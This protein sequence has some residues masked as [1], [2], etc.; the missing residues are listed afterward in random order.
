MCGRFIDPDIRGTEID[1]DQL[2]LDPWSRRYNIKPTNDVLTIDAEGNGAMAR[3]W[4]IP[5]WHK[6]D[7][8]DWKATTF[9]ARIE[10]AASKPTFRGAWRYGR[11]LI[12]AGGYYEWTGPKGAKQ[13]HFICS[14]GNEETLW[15]AGL[16]SVWQDLRTCTIMTR[17]SIPAV[18]D[19]HT[20]MPVI[21]NSEERETWIMGGSDAGFGATA[22]L[23][24]YPVAPLRS[25]EDGPELIEAL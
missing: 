1:F 3:W 16:I 5:T 14:A 4:L 10:E 21:L 11:C 18:S 20:R 13:P 7:L 9:N 6:G 2:K 22:A 23:R 15:F 8:R 17:A 12:P 25:A 19:I 24:H